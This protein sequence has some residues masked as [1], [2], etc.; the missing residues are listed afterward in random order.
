MNKIAEQALVATAKVLITAGV[1][2]V[3]TYGIPACITGTRVVS[4]YVKTKVMTEIVVHKHMKNLDAELET[5][6]I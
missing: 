5:V 2:L 4:N 6:M 3:V 1:T